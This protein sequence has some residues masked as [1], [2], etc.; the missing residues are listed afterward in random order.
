MIHNQQVLF[1]VNQ[2]QPLLHNF[3]N[4]TLNVT[5]MSLCMEW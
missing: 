1:L 2:G 4:N 3:T 5:Q